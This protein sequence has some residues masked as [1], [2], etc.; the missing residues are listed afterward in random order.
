[1][2]VVEAG[3]MRQGCQIACNIPTCRLKVDR[4]PRTRSWRTP[5]RSERKRDRFLSMVPRVVMRFP[6]KL[7]TA[8]S[9]ADRFTIDG[10]T[11]SARHI[12]EQ[13]TQPARP[14]VCPACP[15]SGAAARPALSLVQEKTGHVWVPAKSAGFDRNGTQARTLPIANLKSGHCDNFENTGPPWPQLGTQGIPRVVKSL[16]RPIGRRFAKT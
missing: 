2:V 5:S 3:S 12:E 11:T 6:P 16:G 14:T 1:M 13:N 9:P 8:Q 10:E 15:R 4:R 7:P